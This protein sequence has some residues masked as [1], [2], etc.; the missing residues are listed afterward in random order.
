MG[1]VIE[2]LAD[3]RSKLYGASEAEL[4]VVVQL[5]T[6]AFDPSGQSRASVLSVIEKYLVNIDKEEDGGVA[7][8]KTLCEKLKMKPITAKKPEDAKDSV[9]G[10][11]EN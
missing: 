9:V 3:V 4:K 2:L 8:L 5:T 6:P 10:Y 7:S 11:K 1:E